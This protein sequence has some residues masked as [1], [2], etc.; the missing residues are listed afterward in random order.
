[1]LRI[2][3]SANPQVVF[4]LSGRIEAQDVQELKRLLG[5]E[6]AD[7]GIVFDLQEITLVDRDGVE[8]LARCELDHNIQLRN[9]PPYV[10]E[11]IGIERGGNKPGKLE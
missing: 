3:R 5:L 7:Q 10:R 9:C 2:Q 4:S 8:F 11:W 6:K 1:M